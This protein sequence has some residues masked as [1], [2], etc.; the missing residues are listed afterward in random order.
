MGSSDWNMR[1]RKLNFDKRKGISTLAEWLL[2]SQGFYLEKLVKNFNIDQPTLYTSS[3][4]RDNLS[5]KITRCKRREERRPYKSV[6]LHLC[7]SIKIFYFICEWSVCWLQICTRVPHV[8]RLDD[9]CFW[10]ETHTSLCQ[11]LFRSAISALQELTLA[12]VQEGDSTENL[13]VISTLE[14]QILCPKH[15]KV[16]LRESVASFLIRVLKWAKIRGGASLARA[17]IAQSV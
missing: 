17:G 15:R 14:N 8:P 6:F 9:I 4:H 16:C 7:N 5:V 11:H 13:W 1:T 2:A 12:R 3:W 10:C